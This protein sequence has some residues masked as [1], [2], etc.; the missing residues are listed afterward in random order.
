M[1]RTRK[2]A[3][4]A[5]VMA[6]CMITAACD[7]SGRAEQTETTPAETQ[8][9]LMVEVV[10]DIPSVTTK[11]TEAVTAASEPEERP[12]SVTLKLDRSKVDLKKPYVPADNELGTGRVSYA[13]PMNSIILTLREAPA[14]DAKVTAQ[15][16]SGTEVA[17]YTVVSFGYSDGWSYLVSGG[18]A[19]WCRSSDLTTVKFEWLDFDNVELP[20]VYY[21]HGVFSD[22]VCTVTGSGVKLKAAPEDGA[23]VLGSIK[24]GSEVRAFGETEAAPGWLFI[25]VSA[26][27]VEEGGI[28]E[29]YGWVY[30][31]SG[32]VLNYT[33][34]SSR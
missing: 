11:R 33:D 20:E 25:A 14:E 18:K 22:G 13:Y 30:T 4:L 8:T 16:L 21:D 23:K 9:S 2:T 15:L 17:V 32:R 12:E 6:V 7:R 34:G 28:G 27:Y 24:D 3:A 10:T 5:A 19:G 31:D 1:R 29:L 26:E